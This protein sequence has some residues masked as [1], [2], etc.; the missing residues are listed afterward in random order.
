M[1]ERDGEPTVRQ[2]VRQVLDLGVEMNEAERRQRPMSKSELMEF[3]ARFKMQAQRISEQLDLLV[4][5]V[6]EGEGA[7][8]RTGQSY[9]DAV[10]PPA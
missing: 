6:S 10:E 3:A 1:A 9:P 8:T 2:V 4:S 5:A 7:G